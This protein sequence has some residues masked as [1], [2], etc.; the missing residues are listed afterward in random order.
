M[1]IVE[2][3][4]VFFAALFCFGGC[5]GFSRKFHEQEDAIRRLERNEVPPEYTEDSDAAPPYEHTESTPILIPQA[6]PCRH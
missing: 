5:Y 1:G 2:T 6:D 4:S 3:I